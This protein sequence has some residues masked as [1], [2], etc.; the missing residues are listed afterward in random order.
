MDNRPFVSVL[1][2]TYN[3]SGLLQK[4]VKS[5]LAQSYDHLEVVVSDNASTDDTQN[6]MQDIVSSDVRVRYIRS[7]YN[8]GPI[9]NW[10][11]SFDSATGK[12][13]LVLCDD[14]FLLDIEYIANGVSLLERYNSGLLIADRIIGSCEKKM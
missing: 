6:L 11:K 12:F 1:I 13:C 14:D 7:P 4:A 9:R 8:L 10:R 2:P 3:R 5:A